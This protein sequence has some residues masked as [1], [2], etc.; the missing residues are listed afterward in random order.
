[1]FSPSST[2]VVG[3]TY[4]ELLN[5]LKSLPDGVLPEEPQDKKGDGLT[6]LSRAQLSWA[7]VQSFAVNH[8]TILVDRQVQKTVANH[9]SSLGP[10]PILSEADL[11]VRKGQDLRRR[12]SRS[13]ERI[14]GEETESVATSEEFARNGRRP[15]ELPELRVGGQVLQDA[16][17]D[18]QVATSSLEV[19][20]LAVR[21]K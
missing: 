8:G 4:F 20:H 1:M 19:V 16:A 21:I 13:Q 17:F 18:W 6:A 3:K 7:A 12:G 9:C 10:G 15:V 11:T 2:W 5:L 14:L